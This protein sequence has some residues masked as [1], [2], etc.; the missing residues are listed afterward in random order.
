MIARIPAGAVPT[1]PPTVT[2]VEAH[3]AT[4]SGP[5]LLLDVREPDE[6]RAGHAPQAHHLPLGQID[7]RPLDL[8]RDR[9][10]ITVCRSGR[11]SAVAAERLSAKG[12]EAVDLAGGMVAW[13]TAG[14]PVVVASP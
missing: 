6:W 3:L 11:R 7:D 9:R 12:Y 10:I 13:S 1:T 4:A 2:P 5:A 8:P 14:L